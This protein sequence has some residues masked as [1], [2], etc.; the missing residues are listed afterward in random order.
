MGA[1]LN[2]RS[3]MKTILASVILAF[4]AAVRAADAEL[5]RSNGCFT[6]TWNRA[7]G[8]LASLVLRDDPDGMNWIQGLEDWGEIRTHIRKSNPNLASSG[9]LFE[10]SEKLPFRELREENGRMISVYDN[11]ILRA[12]VVRELSEDALRETYV[13]KN[14]SAA[15]VYLNR[16]DLG[17]LATFNDDYPAADECVRRRCCAHIWCGGGNSWV[18]AVKMGPFP[19]ELALVLQEGSLD[20]YSVRRRVWEGSNDRGDIVLHPDPAVLLPGG[21]LTVGW[22]LSTCDADAFEPELLKRG[23][24]VIA[25]NQ[26]TVFPGENFEISIREPAGRV[27]REIRTPDKGFGAYPFEFVLADGRRARATGR[28]SPAFDDLVRA[29]VRFVIEKQQ[30][31]DEKSPLYGAFLPYD[32]EDE[33]PYFTAEWR[34]MNACRERTAMPL[35]IAKYLQRH[36]D[37]AAAREALELWEAFALRTFYDDAT[38]MVYDGIGKDP[39]FKRLYNAPQMIGFWKEMYR[40]TGE[41][42]YLDRME[43][44]MSVYYRG[45]GADFYPNGCNF[46]EQLVLLRRAGRDVASLE[47]YVREHVANIVRHGIRPPAHEVRYEQTILAPAVTILSAYT[48]QIGKDDAV[49]A[50]LPGLV[51]AL[52]RFNGCQPDY[53]LNE[54]AIR[55]W[56][57]YWFGKR[58]VYGDTLHQ[59]SAL[60]ARAYMYY[61]QAG[62]GTEWRRR[63]EHTYRNVLAMFTP[64]G[65]ATA[66]Y[67]L[68]LT[69]TMVNDDGTLFRPSRRVQGPDPLANDQDSALYNAMASGLFGAYGENPE[70]PREAFDDAGTV[71]DAPYGLTCEYIAEPMGVVRPRFFWKD[72]RA[73]SEWKLSVATAAAGLDRPDVL[74][75]Y[76]VRSNTYVEPDCAFEP[77]RRY[78]WRV[79]AAGRSADASFV[80]GIAEW[81]KPFFTF[82]HAPTEY[83]RATKKVRLDHPEEAVLAVV[84]RGFHRLS[85]NGR[86]VT[87]VCAPNRSHIED[88][89]LLAT[90]YNISSFVRDGEN[91]FEILFSD[92]WGR[93]CGKQAVLSVDGRIETARGVLSVDSSEPW[94]CSGTGTGSTSSWEWWCHGGEYV[95]DAPLAS[96]PVPGVAVTGGTF[97]VSCDCS[98]RDRILR[99]VKPVSVEPSTNGVWRVDMGEAFTGFL[100]LKLKGRAGTSATLE[101]SDQTA[102]ACAFAQR[103]RLDFCAGGNGVFENALDV[104]AGRYWAIRGAEKVEDIEGFVVSCIAERTG[105]FRG[106][107]ALES[108]LR[109]DNDTYVANTFGGITTDC[110]HRERLGYGEATLSSMWGDGLPYYDSAAFYAALLAKW[111][112]SQRPDGSFPHVSPDFHGG[113][114]TFWSCYPVYA[115]R[116]FTRRFPDK[117]VLD[118]LRGPIDRWLDYLDAQTK[119]GL[120]AKYEPGQWGFLGDWAYPDGRTQDWGDT[121]EALYFNSCSYAWAI[122]CALDTDGL[123][124]DADRRRALRVRHAALVSAVERRFYKD[125][126]YCSADAR[127]QAMAL[128]SGTAEAAGHRAETE[129]T[130]LDIVE[131]K[132]Y[133]DGGSPSFTVMLRLMCASDRGRALALKCLRRREAPGYL[134]FLDEGFNTLPEYWTAKATDEGSMMHTCYTGAAGVLI[135]GF[136]GISIRGRD[137][138]IRPYLSR[139]LPSFDAWTE[140]LYGTVAV[141]IRPAGEGYAEVAVRLPRGCR[142]VLE[143][144]G[145][146]PLAF[147]ENR[148]RV[149]IE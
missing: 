140:T 107:A 129:K 145:V 54:T 126:L 134:H 39:R 136:A 45:G 125:G 131:R 116:D 29:R 98:P 34:D 51:D 61:A 71:S 20:W 106:D 147:G 78:H 30:C 94:I 11:G 64:D 139:D 27:R 52:A 62:G 124:T 15:P 25:F 18:R 118:F 121:P 135:E 85:V 53:R 76:T 14:V 120:L 46:S 83:G 95:R 133:I 96:S 2:R 8:A 122:L 6:V 112:S 87:E 5:V 67:L 93:S 35:M 75:G 65:R 82:P 66:A 143:A 128:V 138:V 142:G 3:V 108:V 149:P 101:V 31:R 16:G 130:M 113:G 81:T 23:G 57:G 148:F 90:V 33:S 105:G 109:L 111:A 92:G 89:Y 73:V 115:L 141:S 44:T 10:D 47:A 56:D 144:D 40:L 26:E 60:S 137:V 43:K 69:V 114:G 32:N 84:S 63:A 110:P 28:Y 97:R 103:W 1:S 72:D 17:I 38:G 146:K 102:V 19:K 50:A 74:D 37:D 99:N 13:F 86:R 42:K 58:H 123:V 59:H 79:S 24:A 4:A 36:D 132:G 9:I 91:V 117:R 119:D 127:Y 41:T 70:M 80:T 49:E 68:P 100:R 21:I 104:A 48:T 12:E 88:G 77:F 55:H 22:T 7:N